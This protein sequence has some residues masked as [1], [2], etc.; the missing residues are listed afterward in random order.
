MRVYSKFVSFWCVHKLH[1]GVAGLVVLLHAGLLYVLWLA[2][3][4]SL[5]VTEPVF[6][7]VIVDK[8]VTSAPV[9]ATTATKAPSVARR[10]SSKTSVAEKQPA[11]QNP[12]IVAAPQLAVVSLPTERTAPALAGH[13]AN[14]E[15]A[16]SPQAASP[17]TVS[18]DVSL[19]CPVRPAPVYPLNARKLGETGKVRLRVELDETGRMVASEV[20]Q[21]SG[22][23]RLDEAAI[24]AVKSWRCQP[25]VRDGQPLR[26]VSM[27]SFEFNLND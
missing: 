2:R 9:M 6:A 14:G 25:A 10:A 11:T 24:A 4:D 8:P 23:V 26:I 20:A 27:E 3:G 13:S 17:S 22:F 18:S 16:G 1:I 7:E 5:P 15:V 12:V 21:S 19:T